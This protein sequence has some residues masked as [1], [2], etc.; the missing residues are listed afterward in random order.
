[1]GKVV[2]KAFMSGELRAKVTGHIA[3]SWEGGGERKQEEEDQEAQKV[4]VQAEAGAKRAARLAAEAA[5]F[6]VTVTISIMVEL[7]CLFKLNAGV[8]WPSQSASRAWPPWRETRQDRERKKPRE[9][10]TETDGT[11]R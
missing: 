1:M 2:A 4:Q 11:D 10:E 6:S 8:T 5:P 9:T 3:R 7:P